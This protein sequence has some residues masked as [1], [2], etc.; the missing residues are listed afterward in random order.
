MLS[1]SD[2][3]AGSTRWL[4]G[5]TGVAGV[6]DSEGFFQPK[7]PFFEGKE[8]KMLCR[9]EF[10][11]PSVSGSCVEGC[12]KLL[13]AR[14]IKS[15]VCLALLVTE[16]QPPL[17]WN[18]APCTAPSNLERPGL[19]LSRWIREGLELAGLLRC[20]TGAE[21]R[22]VGLSGWLVQVGYVCLSMAGPSQARA[23]WR[24]L[25]GLADGIS[26]LLSQAL[27]SGRKV[28]A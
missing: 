11:L 26:F 28:G 16:M 6:G 25:A 5:G 18:S 14:Q 24:W 1:Q 4:L 17:V 9:R 3:G 19:I 2:Q 7:Y 10:L 13:R 8:P 15:Y 23:E 20:L 27:E 21:S 12:L 22:A